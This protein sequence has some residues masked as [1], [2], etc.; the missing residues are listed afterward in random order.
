MYPLEQGPD[1]DKMDLDEKPRDVFYGTFDSHYFPEESSAC[2]TSSFVSAQAAED[3]PMSDGATQSSSP[4]PEAMVECDLNVKSPVADHYTPP[5]VTNNLTLLDVRGSQRLSDRGLLQLTHLHNLEVCRLDNCHSVT[6]RG[7]LALARSHRLHTLSM[8]NCRR[9]T[10]EAVLN[11]SHL[12][13]LEN[14]SLDGCRCLTDRSL[15][16]ISN[17]YNLRK[18]DLSQCDLITDVGLEQLEPLDCLEELSL[19]WCRQ[20][21]DQGIRHLVQHP[22]RATTLRILRLA[23]CPIT[24]EGVSTLARLSALEELDLNGCSSIVSSE[25]GNTL[26]RLPHLAVLDISYCPGIL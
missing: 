3:Y 4:V 6:G 7:L 22:G 20:I 1:A 12:L 18:L 17:L 8:A 2:S 13:S 16:A 14:L 9:L 11:I 23:R 5:S 15:A 21:T 19:G 24:D 26:Q 10:D 25:L